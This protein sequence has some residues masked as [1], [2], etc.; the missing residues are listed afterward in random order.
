MEVV[1]EL[2][3]DLSRELTSRTPR[4]SPLHLAGA[5]D[6]TDS[7]HPRRKAVVVIDSKIRI[8]LIN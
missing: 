4:T 2:C 3:M 1:I 7:K 8:E 6:L 5:I